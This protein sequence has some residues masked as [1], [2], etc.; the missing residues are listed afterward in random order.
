VVLLDPRR[1]T[2][3]KTPDGL[4]EA[5]TRL[6][7]DITESYDLSAAEE[8]LL[9]HAARELDLIV[10]LDEALAG[11]D[12]FVE[13]YKGQPVANP[14]LTEVRQH[15]ATYS[16]LMSKIN[17]PSEDGGSTAGSRSASARELANAR[18]ASGA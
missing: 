6:W 13:G 11:A 2:M 8:R 12:L 7:C 14:L 5:G 10:R 17:L 15:R 16:S 18:W 9:E 1:V 3:V 4:L